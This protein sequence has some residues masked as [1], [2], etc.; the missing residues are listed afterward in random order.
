[1]GY[2]GKEETLFERDD[3][4]KLLPQEVCL[5]TLKGTPSIRALP[6]TRGK[7]KRI[8]SE[9]K[10]GETDSDQD[11]KIILDHCINPKYTEEEV[12]SLKP[13]YAGAIVTSILAL[14]M[15]VEEETL[16]DKS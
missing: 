2:L 14:S 8:I 15:G 3:E 9:A 16:K 7:L 12:K 5:K 1:M 4:G 6:M 11:A 13:A 10:D